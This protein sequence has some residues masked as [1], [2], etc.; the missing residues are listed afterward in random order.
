MFC[1]QNNYIFHIVIIGQTYKF[2]KKK[3]SKITL[4]SV[5]KIKLVMVIVRLLH[6]IFI[7]KKTLN[8]K[9]EKS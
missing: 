2:Q 1:I 6:K 3:W 9:L 5:K 7:K 4:I 8:K